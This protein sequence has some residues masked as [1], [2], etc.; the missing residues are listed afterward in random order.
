[1]K[2]RGILSADG[3]PGLFRGLQLLA[4][5]AACAG[6]AVAR[7]WSAGISRSDRRAASPR[8]KCAT[9][10]MEI[11]EAAAWEEELGTDEASLK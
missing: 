1:M 2:S 4:R 10:G 11:P 8:Q 3:C 5:P 9:I 7:T 6:S